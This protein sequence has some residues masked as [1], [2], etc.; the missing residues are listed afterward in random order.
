MNKD[1]IKLKVKLVESP[2]STSFFTKGKQYKV[3]EIISDRCFHIVADNGYDAIC[4]IDKCAYLGFEDW[5]I[6]E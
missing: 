1:E 6:I 2:K 3:E 5:I 4:S